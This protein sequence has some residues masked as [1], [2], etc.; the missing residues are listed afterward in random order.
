M[1]MKLA[2]AELATLTSEELQTELE[3][4]DD[5][6]LMKWSCGEML[7]AC[8][9]IIEASK[10]YANAERIRGMVSLVYDIRRDPG[11]PVQDECFGDAFAI[12]KVAKPVL[13]LFY[14]THPMHKKRKIVRKIR[15]DTTTSIDGVFGV[16]SATGEFIPYTDPWLEEESLN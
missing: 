8:E 3:K 7:K 15:Y 9:M 14:F 13:D 2:I 1:D 5:T 4:Y 12:K 16:Q 11:D 10:Y 6:T